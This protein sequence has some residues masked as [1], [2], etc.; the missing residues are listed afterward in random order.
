MAEVEPLGIYQFAPASRHLVIAEDIQTITL[1]VQR[2]YGS[3]SN[4]TQLSFTTTAGSAAAGED[5]IA[6]AD[7]RL[8]FDSPGQTNAS[9]RLSILDDALSEADEFFHVKLTDVQAVAPGLTWPDSSPRLDP[10]HS[11]AT[12]TILA[13]DVTGGVLSIG[14]ERVHTPEDGV[15]D[16]QQKGRIVLKVRRSDSTATDVRVRVR[17][18]GGACLPCQMTHKLLLSLPFALT[19]CWT[20]FSRW[21]YDCSSFC[22][23]IYR[24]PGKGGPRLP[25]GD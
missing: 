13:S 2:L 23:G 18:Y 4:R 19:I 8:V 14:P 24:S 20:P 9:F 17:A 3:R 25:R 6:V 10:Q 1:Y 22:S 15:D 12:V 21:D 5:F 16:T 11:V 7:G